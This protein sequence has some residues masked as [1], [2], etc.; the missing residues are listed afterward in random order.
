MVLK[1]ATKHA[2]CFFYFIITF[3]KEFVDEG[4]VVGIFHKVYGKK[5]VPKKKERRGRPKSQKIDS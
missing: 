3:E 2:H 4:H 1:I 5:P